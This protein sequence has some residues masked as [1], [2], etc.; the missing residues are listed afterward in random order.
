MTPAV[1]IVTDYPLSRWFDPSDDRSVEE[2]IVELLIDHL[3]LADRNG[4]LH[5]TLKDIPDPM[6]MKGVF[7]GV[8]LLL[9]TIRKGGRTLI[10]GDY[11]VDGITATV[12]LIRFFRY[13][14]YQHYESFIPNRFA[15]GYGLTSKTVEIILA[16]KPD[17]VITVDNGITAIQEIMTIRQ[18]GIDVIVT[19]HHLPLNQEI[20]D[21]TVI[22]PKQ[23]GCGFPFKDLSGVGVVF[24]F[25]IAVRLILRKRGYWETRREPNLLHH[26]DLVAIGTIADQVPLLGLN[27]LFARFGL[28][29]MTRRLHE[30]SVDNHYFYLRVFA[31]KSRLKSFDSNSIAFKLAPMLN[32]TGRMKDADGGVSFLLSDTENHAIS[33]YHYIERLNLQRRKRQKVMVKQAVDKARYLLAD[34][35]GLLIY[36][37][38][39]HE[40]LIGIVASR[41]VDQFR[42]PC[43]VMTDGEPGVLKA[44]CR[45]KDENIMTI[46]QACEQYIDRF[47]GHANAAGC[48]IRKENLGPFHQQFTEACSQMMSVKPKQTCRANIEVRLDMLTYRLIDA[49]NVFEPF[50]QQN[51]K[52]VFVLRNLLLPVPSVMAGKHLKWILA[53]DLEAI[54]WNGT[55][56]P[57]CGRNCD[58][59][60]TLSQHTY[61]ETKRRQLIVEAIRTAGDSGVSRRLT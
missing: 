6:L 48:S 57:D 2:Q 14:G 31:D 21:C 26:L 36:D 52:P 5:A 50:G 34:N 13:L 19:D 42:Q 37:E 18:A 11:D 51:R 44:S 47:G 17:L 39:F 4:F 33:R 8:E 27:R 35:Q 24:I 49:L 43:I 59:A 56:Y 25:L 61:R 60:F 10:V 12:L 1:E 54:F 20:P 28:N 58:L 7:A 46:L 41:L 16:N 55:R 45:S 38:T 3:P 53:N 29:Q 40:G 30:P 22:N 23:P 15:H 9:E 32:A